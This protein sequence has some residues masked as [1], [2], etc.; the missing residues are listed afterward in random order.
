M[1]R[2]DRHP[3]RCSLMNAV[4]LNWDLFEHIGSKFFSV[5]THLQ[6]YNANKWNSMIQYVN[7]LFKYN[8]PWMQPMHEVEPRCPDK[9]GWLS[10]HAYSLLTSKAVRG[11][12]AGLRPQAWGPSL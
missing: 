9:L 4:I 5:G 1:G 10:S 2:L 12:R 11:C 7:I 8:F 3:L 6:N